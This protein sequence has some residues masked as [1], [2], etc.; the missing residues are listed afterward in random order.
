MPP[1][2][3]D[4][5]SISK[6]SSASMDKAQAKKPRHRHSAHQLA[7][8]NELY[9]RDEHP[10]LDDRTQLAER[11]GMCVSLIS[12]GMQREL[13]DRWFIVAGRSRRSTLGSRISGRLIKSAITT[14]QQPPPPLP[15]SLFPRHLP[16]H[17]RRC[18]SHRRLRITR[19]SSYRPSRRCSLRRRRRRRRQQ[20]NRSRSPN[21]PVRASTQPRHRCI[22]STPRSDTHPITLPC[23]PIPITRPLS[24]P[25][26]LSSGTCTT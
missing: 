1:A 19:R 12:C 9:D 3:Q 18:P 25:A 15:A 6:E 26:T 16:R 5:A 13:T 17:S 22:Q 24:T 7:L 8:L 20:P 11:L 4:E 2:W 23:P 14:K 10:P 21:T